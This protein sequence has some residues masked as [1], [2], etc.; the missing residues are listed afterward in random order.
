MSL[1]SFYSRVIR[2]AN[3]VAISGNSCLG[4]AAFKQHKS[5][6]RNKKRTVKGKSNG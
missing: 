1:K 3:S 6:Q 4:P 2:F 5:H